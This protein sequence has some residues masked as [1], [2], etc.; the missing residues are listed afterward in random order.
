[1]FADLELADEMVVEVD[2]DEE[3]TSS[4]TSSTLSNTNWFGGMM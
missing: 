3:D 2:M 4:G 1:M